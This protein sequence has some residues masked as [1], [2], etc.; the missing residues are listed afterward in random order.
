MPQLRSEALQGCRFA[1][2]HSPRGTPLQEINEFRYYLA[3][4]YWDMGEYYDAAV[5]GEFLARRYPDR[6]E[7]Q[8]AAKLTLAAYMKLLGDDASDKAWQFEKDRMIGIAQFITDRWPN[9]PAADEAWAILIDVAI[10]DRDLVKMIEYLG[11]VSTESPRRG[12][13]EVKTGQTLWTAYL[14]SLSLPE[15]KRPSKEKLAEMAAQS[16]KALEDGVARLRKPVEAGGKVS[17][18]L[19][20]AV[21]SLTQ[22]YLKA[23]EAQKAIDILDDPDIGPHMLATENHKV[24][25]LGNFRVEALK[26]DL[27]GLH[28]RAGPRKS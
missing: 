3:Y 4:L 19:A 21:L 17:T 24:A 8:Q 10:N 18:T 28:R 16:R 1:L 2:T 13:I 20:A 26:S 14:K 25:F 9:S 27:A 11:H 7:A 5:I 15:A 23:G 22:V 6:R 12:A